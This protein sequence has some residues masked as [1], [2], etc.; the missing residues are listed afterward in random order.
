MLHSRVHT[1]WISILSF[2]KQS[3]Q[4]FKNIQHLKC[5]WLKSLTCFLYS[6]H[7][8]LNSLTHPNIFF[9]P[10]L[11][12]QRKKI[13]IWETIKVQL[14]NHIK[15][16]LL[17]PQWPLPI[18]FNQKRQF[19]DS[20]IFH[21]MAPFLYNYFYYY[22]KNRGDVWAKQKQNPQSLPAG[23]KSKVVYKGWKFS[24]LPHITVQYLSV[25]QTQQ[26]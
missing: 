1:F 6:F 2:Y 18:Y 23:L 17:Q 3:S 21:W 20:C 16:N 12:M 5:I 15:T 24:V 4:I 25:K 10:N 7:Q 22:F 9:P 26:S 14:T 19:A 13:C 8:F 11:I